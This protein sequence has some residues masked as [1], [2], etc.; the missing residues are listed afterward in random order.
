MHEFSLIND[1]LSKIDTIA[2]A[3]GATRVKTINVRLGA[4]AHL[5][6]QH[7]REHFQEAARGGICEHAELVV[8]ASTDVQ[9]PDAQSV[10]LEG[11]EVEL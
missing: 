2:R 1:L 4:L 7:F 3:Q 10:Y 11:L 9:S 8:L 5:S 6:P